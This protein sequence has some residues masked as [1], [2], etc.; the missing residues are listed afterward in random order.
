MPE[1]FLAREVIFRSVGSVPV[2]WPTTSATA[3]SPQ[4]LLCCRRQNGAAAAGSPNIP[5][6]WLAPRPIG[7]AAARAGSTATANATNAAAAVVAVASVRALFI[8]ESFSPRVVQVWSKRRIQRGPC[9][10]LASQLTGGLV[11][12]GLGAQNDREGEAS[13]PVRRVHRQRQ[14]AQGTA[15]R[16]DP[17][18]EAR[19]W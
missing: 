18:R 1:L 6:C 5:V 14:R 7:L 8:N 3:I 4:S 2:I 16:Q 19:L 9:R 12:Q 10:N 15:V 13:D 11:D 17:G